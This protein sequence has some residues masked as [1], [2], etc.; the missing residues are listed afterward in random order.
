MNFVEFNI[1]TS[2][3]VK[4]IVKDKPKYLYENNLH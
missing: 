1:K 4:T 3:H 2:A